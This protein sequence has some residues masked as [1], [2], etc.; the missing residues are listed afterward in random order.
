MERFSPPFMLFSQS[1]LK[2]STP[3]RSDPDTLGSDPLIHSKTVLF[4][5]E[6]VL[7]L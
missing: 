6:V 7:D 5:F 2:F 4:L 1:F 3:S